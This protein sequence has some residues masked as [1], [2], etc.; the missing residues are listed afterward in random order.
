MDTLE[1]L[2]P[3]ELLRQGAAGETMALRPDKFEPPSP[4]ELAQVFPQLEILG[5]IGKGGMGAVYKVRQREIDRLA[6]LKILPPEIGAQPGFAERFAREARALAKL[7]H[8]GIV[9]LYEFGQAGELYFFL[10]EFVDGVTLRQILGNERMSPREAMA[11]VPQIC[12]ALQYAHDQ[13]V[14][15]RDIKPENILLDRLGRVKVADFGIAKLAGGS[16]E[17]MASVPWGADSFATHAGG[18]MGTPSYMA[19]EQFEQPAAVD[20]RADIYALGVVF[21]QMLTGEL[22]GKPTQAPSRKVLVDVRLDEVVLR[23]MEEQP[24]LRFQQA[25]E[26]KT[27]VETIASSLRQDAFSL[28]G[29]VRDKRRLRPLEVGAAALALVILAWLLLRH[30]SEGGGRDLPQTTAPA[31]AAA[32]V[33]TAPYDPPEVLRARLAEA[34]V[35]LERTRALHDTGSA[36]QADLRAAEDAVAV[37]AAQL[38]GDP[39]KVTQAEFDAA[40][41]SAGYAE[42]SFQSGMISRAEYEKAKAALSIAEAKL[43]AARMA[44]SGPTSQNDQDS[45]PVTSP[46]T[47]R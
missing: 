9:T 46:G 4:E 5:L 33:A 17:T 7:N 3:A 31:S 25:G 10:M 30:G 41:R 43:K 1:G 34:R 23:A 38:E 26:V 16:L 29:L 45:G 19:P 35:E 32:P 12:D 13:G 18:V 11:V 24:A 37:I 36:S 28:T 21:Y 39:V 42:A 2:D 22:P 8:P 15:H 27:R 44:K 14:V 47:P 40:G 6:A 20:H